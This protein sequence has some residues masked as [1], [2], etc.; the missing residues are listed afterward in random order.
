M[1]KA[2]KLSIVAEK[3][4]HERI[5]KRIEEV[6]ATGYS[7]F[8]GGGKGRHTLH[9]TD[10]ASLVGAFS[11]AK[12]EVILSDRAAAEKLAEAVV[13]EFFDRYPGIVYLEDVEVVRRERF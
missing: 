12:I 9:P 11:I 3:I 1:I 13:S 7:V 4:L 5:L 10:R 8:E 2:V 6:G